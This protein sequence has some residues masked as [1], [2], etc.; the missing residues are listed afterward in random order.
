MSDSYLGEILV[1]DG[2][3]PRYAFMPLPKHANGAGA[4][5]GGMLMTLADQ[6]FGASVQ[7]AALGAKVVT[8]SLTTQFVAPAQIGVWIEGEAEIVRQTRSLVFV[9]GQLFQNGKAVL[10]AS[11]IWKR[12]AAF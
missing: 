5:H 11:G 6:V 2:P 12:M 8:V 3:S 1:S 4:V 9:T 7:K 10:M